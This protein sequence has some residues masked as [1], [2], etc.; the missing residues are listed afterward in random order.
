[1][2]LFLSKLLILLII[3]N[4]L[5][6]RFLKNYWEAIERIGDWKKNSDTS[7]TGDRSKSAKEAFL[8]FV[9]IGSSKIRWRKT[10]FISFFQVVRVD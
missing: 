5:L 1:M 2:F 4:G 8:S 9:A 6:D 7:E 3:L 10:Y